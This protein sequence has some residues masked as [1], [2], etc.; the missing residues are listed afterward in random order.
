M[1]NKEDDFV[2]KKFGEQGQLTVLPWDGERR[3]GAKCYKVSCSV[4]SRDSELFGDGTFH[5][6]KSSLLNG[7]IPC[8]CGKGRHWTEQQLEVV[9]N[10]VCSAQNITF[11]GFH[12]EWKGVFTHIKQQCN[13]CQHMWTTGTVSNVRKGSGCPECQ[14]LTLVK[15]DE[16][17]VSSFMS[18]GMLQQGTV[19]WRSVTVRWG[20]NYTCPI[21]SNDEYVQKGLCSGV[22][23][24]SS[25]S[26]Q[27]GS[28]ACRCGSKF[29]WTKE[30]R[31]YQIMKTISDEQLDVSFS[32]WLDDYQGNTTRF[33]LI[34]H[35]HGAWTATVN[36][37]LDR[38]SRC[39]DCA[40][41]GYRKSKPG[42]LYVM[43][44]GDVTK[45]GI[46][47]RSVKS[48][49]NDI[50]RRLPCSMSEPFK[51]A[52]H[53]HFV[54]GKVPRDI[55]TTLKKFLNKTYKRVSEKFDGYTE[56]FFNVD[57]EHLLSLIK[58]AKLA[59]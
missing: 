2:G 57:R 41:S 15:S 18:S 51:V 34:C 23:Q 9:M 46:T 7:Q 37:F 53:E 14:R 6:M 11:C 43:V 40:E 42:N 16:V 17:M 27:K 30:Q 13:T 19:F 31:E 22:F 21:C 56:C 28:I 35:K 44:S 36:T 20:W 1:S 45:V 29:N 49:L 55:E 8:G 54:N 50:N 33:E 4:C 26:L 32:K 48:R 47:N 58:D 59:A 5:V 3:N 38:G 39:P 52:F 24:S 25:H 10:R 12:G